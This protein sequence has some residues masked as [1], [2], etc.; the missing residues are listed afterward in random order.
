MCEPAGGA[1]GDGRACVAGIRCEGATALG[2]TIAV[3]P[4]LKSVRLSGNAIGNAGLQALANTAIRA[5]S[6]RWTAG[7][8]RSQ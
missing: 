3:H 5:N 8:A 1:G 2:P 6:V 7:L 4:A